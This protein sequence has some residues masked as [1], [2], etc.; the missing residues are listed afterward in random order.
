MN[1]AA[2][3]AHR[4]A[5]MQLEHAVSDRNAADRQSHATLALAAACLMLGHILDERLGREAGA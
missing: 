5:I 4:I 1:D 3:G 2:L